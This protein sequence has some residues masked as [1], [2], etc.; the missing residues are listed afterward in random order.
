MGGAGDDTLGSTAQYAYASVVGGTGSDS[1]YTTNASSDA[2][3]STILGGDGNDTIDFAGGATSSRIKGEA[4]NDTITVGGDALGSTV[5]GGTGNDSI[6]FSGFA[7]NTKIVGGTGND[8]FSFAEQES[9]AGSTLFFGSASG[10][11]SI[12][13]AAGNTVTTIS[14]SMTIAVDSSL[15][16]TSAFN[17]SQT[18]GASTATITSILRVPVRSSSRN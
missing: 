1:I 17:F 9:T 4:G 5:T 6:V 15:G 2:D 16:A 12:Y 11:D 7:T 18:S 14:G 13:F 10:M 3:N 8:T